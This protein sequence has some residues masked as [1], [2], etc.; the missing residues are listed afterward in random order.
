MTQSRF[1]KAGLLQESP[2]ESKGFLYTDNQ[3]EDLDIEKLLDG[4]SDCYRLPRNLQVL[5]KKHIIIT[6]PLFG[7]GGTRLGGPDTVT[8]WGQ[9]LREG[10]EISAWT[11]ELTPI[12]NLEELPSI[13]QH[14]QPIHHDK[15]K[16]ILAEKNLASD[17]CYLA[18]IGQT[19][20]LTQDILG[21]TV[22]FTLSADQLL[23]I[24]EEELRT[25]LACIPDS[26][27]VGLEFK[28]IQEASSPIFHHYLLNHPSVILK[29]TTWAEIVSL[30][31]QYPHLAELDLRFRSFSDSFP[32]FILPPSLKHLTLRGNIT[33]DQFES[34]ILPC[35]NLETLEFIC[36]KGNAPKIIL[37]KSLKY[38]KLDSVT[39]DQLTQIISSCPNLEKLTSG[40]ITGDIVKITF[41]ASL[42]HLDLSET[43]IIGE[44]FAPSIRNCS[45]L[46][47]LILGSTT[48]DIKRFKD[49]SKIILPASLKH[50]ELSNTEITGD[51]VAKLISTCPNLEKL[52]L[53]NCA[54][55]RDVSN[56]SLPTS[57][58]DLTLSGVILAEDQLV[59]LLAPCQNLEVL[60]IDGCDNIPQGLQ[61]PSLRKLVAPQQC[62][63]NQLEQWVLDFPNLKELTLY[64]LSLTREEINDFRKKHPQLQ[65]TTPFDEYLYAKDSD[66]LQVNL[67]S[68]GPEKTTEPPPLDANTGPSNQHLNANQIFRYKENGKPDPHH[69]RLEI[70]NDIAISSK[71]RIT[72]FTGEYKQEKIEQ[73]RDQ[74]ANDPHVFLGRVSLH[75][76]N[77]WIPLPSLTSTDKLTHIHTYPMVDLELGYC[78]SDARYYVRPKKQYTVP[79]DLSF[80]IKAD[81]QKDHVLPQDIAQEDV[82]LIQDLQFDPEGRLIENAAKVKIGLLPRDVQIQILFTYFNQF[83]EKALKHPGANQIDLLNAVIQEKAGVCRH[84]TLAFIALAKAFNIPARAV[85]NDIHAFVE[86]KRGEGWYRADLGGGLGNLTI[87]PLPPEKK[88]PSVVSKEES[89]EIELAPD[90]PF[91]TWDTAH[92][93]ATSMAEYT[94]KLLRQAEHLKPGSKNI[95][96]VLDRKQILS[97]YTEI[98]RQKTSGCYFLSDLNYVTDKVR[99]IDNHT[100]NSYTDASALKR[101]L[102]NAKP[103]DVLLVD[104]TDYEISHVG[105]NSMMDVPRT[106]K[107]MP[108][109]D[110]VIVMGLIDKNQEMAED[111]YSRFRI[112]SDMPAKLVSKSKPLLPAPHPNPKHDGAT[113]IF[114]Y[115]ENWRSLM[116]G[117]IHAQNGSFLFEESEFVKALS[118]GQNTFVFKNA[119][120][121]LTEFRLFMIELHT[122]RTI[123]VN[124]KAY[125]L[126]EK[127][128]LLRDD[129]PYLLSHPNCLLQTYPC[130]MPDNAYVLNSMSFA[131]L[132]NCFETSKNGNL[133]TL[134]G[135]LQEHK[136]K[137]LPLFITETLSDL[138][139]AK[140]LMHAQDLSLHLILSKGVRLPSEVM[141][142]AKKIENATIEVNTPIAQFIETNDIDFAAAKISDAFHISVNEKTTYADLTGTSIKISSDPLQFKYIE[143]CLTLALLEGKHVVLEG[144]LSPALVKQLE[145]LFLPT[146][147]ISTNG[148]RIPI[149]AKARLSIITDQNPGC[150]FVKH[151]IQ[152]YQPEEYWEVLEKKFQKYNVLR[153]KLACDLL[154]KYY[155]FSYIELKSMLEY[156]ARRPDRNPLKSI[157]RMK[158]NYAALKL[159]IEKAWGKSPTKIAAKLAVEEQRKTILEE[160]LIDHWY[161]FVAG[162]SGVGKS[163]TIHKLLKQMDFEIISIEGSLEDKLLAWVKPG[164][165]KALFFDEAN[166]FEQGAFDILEGLYGK[167]PRLLIRGEYYDVPPDNKLIFAGNFGH[168]AGRQSLNFIARHGN[169]IAF[170]EFTDEFLR[171]NIVRVTCGGIKL[172]DEIEIKEL[173]DAFLKTYYHIN[174]E[175]PDK[176]PLTARNLQMMTL[177]Y[178]ELRKEISDPIQAMW[179]AAYEEVVAVCKPQQYKNFAS[180]IKANHGVDVRTLKKALKE[181]VKSEENLKSFTHIKTRVNPVRVLNQLMQI[182]DRKIKS[183]SLAQSG[184]NGL[185]LE[186][187]PGVGKSYLAI[188]YLRAQEFEDGDKV[189]WGMAKSPSK[190][191]YHLRTTD[192]DEIKAKLLQAFHEGAVVIIDE[193]NTLVIEH[194]LNAFL[195]GKT[196]EGDDPKHPGFF[197]IATQNPISFGKRKVLSDAF[198]NR[199]QNLNLKDYRRDDVTAIIELVSQLDPSS[200]SILSGKLMEAK[201]YAQKY[202]YKP[203]PT[204]RDAFEHAKIISGKA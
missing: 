34:L 165:K 174:S 138:E 53:D 158:P 49:T 109:P 94:D 168:F 153:L 85:F 43:K 139:W 150:H 199:F 119:P 160:V 118:S 15:L 101:F 117:K 145:G 31:K 69:Y 113:V 112:I 130:T 72:P 108:I 154:K 33:W 173:T 135:I 5:K 97:L 177:R 115:D 11:G 203:E 35:S 189:P 46:E 50:L 26:P 66:F 134:N 181:N 74:E 183:P 67:E 2:T 166:L 192:P 58:T 171:N 19:Q 8:L 84:R 27:R 82:N 120:W 48:M 93:D 114:F 107:G 81:L 146:P 14:V 102:T 75:Y 96:S 170:K 124:G 61:L 63:I 42:K 17:A 204:P 151:G 127:F 104:W 149:P 36:P 37:P 24:P 3:T 103:G 18:G 111:F 92:I 197:V 39:A 99:Y 167:P 157:L 176:H 62:T 55:L 110:G 56:I 54:W 7:L 89:S 71:R 78:D 147:Y 182:R 191:Y 190:R 30:I 41:P 76:S 95:L 21:A 133:N 38:L 122:N 70:H 23:E 169:V 152:R 193:I 4:R 116:L 201:A 25:L 175:S 163:T 136:N 60:D 65:I 131:S 20:L 159:E 79:I 148:K 90:N 87:N 187:S 179:M 202:H 185:L 100:G 156:L 129:K 68:S 40:S 6:D 1:K 106:I 47:T 28:N 178:V 198:L 91:R 137:V 144:K 142:F 172:T 83:E 52:G 13:L 98:A 143:G 105:Y 132:F 161:V 12:S 126:P 180:W 16:P 77:D 44:Q 29:C 59:K 141:K 194:I 125:F 57:L 162:P 195:S 9:L 86:V 51:Q 80:T 22:N 196:P 123:N 186:G 88:Q 188:E 200:A 140:I 121:H 73:L 164:N 184:S 45:N 128:N 64:S 155:T 10:F 32:E